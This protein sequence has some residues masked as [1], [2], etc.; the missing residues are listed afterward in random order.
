[1]RCANS[2]ANCGSSSFRS[3]ATELSSASRPLLLILSYYG[4]TAPGPH[5]NQIQRI[6]KTVLWCAYWIGLGVLSSIG[7]GTGLHTFIIYL[8]PHIA[9][10]TLAAFECHSLDFPEPPYP[11]DVTCPTDPTSGGEV[12]LWAIMNK[13]RLECLMWGAGTALGELPPY[14]MARAARLSGQEPEDEDYAEYIAHI[15]SQRTGGPSQLSVIDR[16]K[17]WVEKSVLKVGFFGILA[18]ASI[19]N[20]LF[21]LAGIVCGHSLISFWRF[22]GATLIGKAIVKAHLQ[23]VFVIM[24]FSEHHMDH[25]IN[26]L[27]LVPAIGPKLQVIFREFLNEQ[28]RKLH[29]SPD[30]EYK[31]PG[32]S[33]LQH[34]ISLVVFG[35]IVMFVVSI[36][37]SLAQAYHKRVCRPQVDAN[38]RRQ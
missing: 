38:K 5:Q 15:E 7:L 37:N 20:P 35:M 28:K 4:Y 19:P 13:V 3:P 2:S 16:L 18:C 24:A 17:L 27:K 10:V 33:L 31:E 29:R 6:E 9:R 25:L 23:M 22:F 30:E 21:D 26:K 11:E 34:L 36:I 14:F 12:T 32:T 1:M 8:G